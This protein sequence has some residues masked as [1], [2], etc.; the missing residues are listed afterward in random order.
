[1]FCD[2]LPHNLIKDILVGIIKRIFQREGS[3]YIACNDRHAVL[4]LVQIES[5]IY[6]LIRK[7]VKFAPFSWTIFKLN[8]DP[9]YIDKL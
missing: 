4:P 7:C 8:F 3:L 6:G 1:M 5:I 2:R 9:N